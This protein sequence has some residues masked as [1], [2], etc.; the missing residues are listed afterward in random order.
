MNKPAEELPQGV[1]PS[2][3]EVSQTPE[4]CRNYSG[5]EGY[6]WRREQE[7]ISKGWD[8][9]ARGVCVCVCVDLGRGS[10]WGQEVGKGRT[11]QCFLYQAGGGGVHPKS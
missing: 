2:R 9:T 8:K 4:R 6:S 7:G 1:D 11:G 3:R 10:C 5:K